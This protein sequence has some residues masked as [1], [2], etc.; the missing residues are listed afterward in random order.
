MKN[1]NIT[2]TNLFLVVGFLT[3][4]FVS[5]CGQEET[6]SP[7]KTP[8]KTKTQEK[9]SIPTATKKTAPTQTNTKEA[10][11]DPAVTMEPASTSDTFYTF[12]EDVEIPDCAP[13]DSKDDLLFQEV[14][15]AISP[16]L[17]EMDSYRYRT[18]Y[19]Y[20][21]GEIY[22]EDELALQIIG[23]HSSLMP[24]NEEYH[25][26]DL[27]SNAYKQSHT[28]MSDLH[29]GEQSEMILT[30]E[31][32]WTR[33]SDGSGWIEIT[34]GDRW[35]IANLADIF[36]PE[37]AVALVGNG[38][39][40][41]LNEQVSPSLMTQFEVIDG[42]KVTHRC[43]KPEPIGE[44]EEPYNQINTVL[45]HGR[46]LYGFLTDTEIHLWTSEDDSQLIRLT[47]KGS[48]IAERYYEDGI[49]DHDPANDFLL[50]VD[51]V[52]VNQPLEIKPPQSDQ[53]SLTIPDSRPE[54]LG[55]SEAPYNQFPTPPDATLANLEDYSSE[56]IQANI[57]RTG[58][59]R[60]IL[61]LGPPRE[62]LPFHRELTNSIM[63]KRFGFWDQVSADR[64]PVYETDMDLY[65]L[66][67]F[68]ADEMAKL[69]WAL[70]DA[71][72]QLG[73]P[74]YLL[75]FTRGAFSI[76]VV[77]DGGMEK[78][79]RIST[80][81]P[82]N[83]EVIEN[84][85]SEWK[86]LTSE[87]SDLLSNEVT[88][89]TID[90]S[91]KI[92]IGT[93]D[94]VS[95][96]NGEDWETFTWADSELFNYEIIDIAIDNQEHAWILTET[97][98]SVFDGEQWETFTSSNSDLISNQMRTIEIDNQDRAWIATN[99]G[100]SVFDG[101]S[102]TTYTEENYDL[103]YRINDIMVDDTGKVWVG[104]WDGISVFDGTDWI[105]HKHLYEVK[106]FDIDPSGQPWIGTNA[107]GVYSLEGATWHE[108]ATPQYE[109]STSSPDDITLLK[110]DDL[111]RT[112]TVSKDQTITVY[113]GDQVETYTACGVDNAQQDSFEDSQMNFDSQNRVW[114]RLP[115]GSFCVLDENGEWLDYTP[116][117]RN[118]LHFLHTPQ[119]W[120]RTLPIDSQGRIWVISSEGIAVFTLPSP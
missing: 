61:L 63:T 43:W 73:Y 13:S 94:G 114:L 77:L 85:L 82:P 100:I 2:R 45:V 116:A 86:F 66:V 51:L 9:V 23:E 64:S 72:F 40:I 71:H 47:V 69:G 74:K 10:T 35:H 1:T 6:S 31:G 83:D 32:I 67:L 34:Q 118:T 109:P 115:G 21:S 7:I 105:S 50:W 75:V 17:S 48:H 92:W 91:G 60:E 104:N 52:D 95:V 41:T 46:D 11:S 29:T 54:S 103:Q 120:P 70:E 93:E 80:I 22:A 3:F 30:E 57:D 87:N 55:D 39:A 5:G 68:Y 88:N 24:D 62:Y 119:S 106:A 49:L 65:S 110:I 89:I 12:K 18:L 14:V 56:V 81:L 101:I 111:G 117:D 99:D 16:K 113:D 78:E 97:G 15:E 102:W 79:N 20:K 38:G 33:N 28:I 59:T 76:P 58:I 25:A 37:S 4:I 27:E 112:W 26:V 84:V 8:T 42:E 90:E 98:L 36:S 108:H 96:L 19:Y 53:V 107:G 44:G